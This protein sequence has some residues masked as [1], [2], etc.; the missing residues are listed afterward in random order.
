MV[1]KTHTAVILH[2][3]EETTVTEFEDKFQLELK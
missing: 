1:C 2:A 3:A